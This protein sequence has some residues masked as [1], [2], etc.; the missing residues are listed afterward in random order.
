MVAR[1]ISS[2][3]RMWRAANSSR[4]LSSTVQ[5]Y[6]AGSYKGAKS[7]SA[8]Q[9]CTAE[10]ALRQEKREIGRCQYVPRGHYDAAL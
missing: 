9:G 4:D 8:L 3:T 7:A 6:R 5:P 2:A 10:G 1:K